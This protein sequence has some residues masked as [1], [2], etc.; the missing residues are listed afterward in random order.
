MKKR[1]Y[2]LI[3]KINKNTKSTSSKKFHEAKKDAIKSSKSSNQN[4]FKSCKIIQK[5]N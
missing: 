5:P 1:C 4:N 2:H 3:I